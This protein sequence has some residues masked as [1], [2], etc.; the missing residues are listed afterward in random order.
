MVAGSPPQQQ[1]EVARIIGSIGHGREFRRN[2]VP[3]VQDDRDRALLESFKRRGFDP[4]ESKGSP[5]SLVEC[6]GEYYVEGD[7]HRRA[8]VAH[9]LK[10]RVIQAEVLP[11][12]DTMRGRGK[13]FPKRSP[14]VFQVREFEPWELERIKE[15]VQKMA[16]RLE[17]TIFSPANRYRI[18]YYP[19]DGFVQPRASTTG[20]SKRPPVLFE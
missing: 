14:C 12:A 6:C 5:I 2:W 20:G 11:L 7:G 18:W 17:V 8:S 13:L 15:K 4:I 10:L 19:P 16:G 1:V 9:R 3:V